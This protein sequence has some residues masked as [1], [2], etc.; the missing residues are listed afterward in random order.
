MMP[1][2]TENQGE[3]LCDMSE[4]ILQL[5]STLTDANK[6]KVTCLIETLLDQQLSD[7]QSSGSQT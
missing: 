4:D 5:Y 1:R 3:L 2:Q 6:Q 7:Q